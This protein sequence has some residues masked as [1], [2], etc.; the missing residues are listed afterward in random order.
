MLDA[1]LELLGLASPGEGRKIVEQG[2][3]GW[4]HWDQQISTMER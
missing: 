4:H 1:D 2:F 3:D